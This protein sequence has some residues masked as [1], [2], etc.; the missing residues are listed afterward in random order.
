MKCRP[1]T[2]STEQSSYCT[3]CPENTFSGKGAALC[4]A[5]DEA[6]QY[7]GKCWE[8]Q[9]EFCLVEWFDTIVLVIR[10]NIVLCLSL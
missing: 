9:G 5:C 4:E 6:T 8:L 10:S 7:S 2:H 3:L 1:G